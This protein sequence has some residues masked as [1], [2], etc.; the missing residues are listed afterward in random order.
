MTEQ[1]MRHD[2]HHAARTLARRPGFALLAILTLAVV[3]RGMRLTAFGVAIGLG[4][5]YLGRG[6]TG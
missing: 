5:A 3:G 1:P 2:L 4:L 6:I